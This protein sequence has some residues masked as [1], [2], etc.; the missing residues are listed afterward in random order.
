MAIV[1]DAIAS[2]TSSTPGTLY[3]WSHTVGAALTDDVLV[4]L[5]Y[6]MG[7]Q[8]GDAPFTMTA[9]YDSVP[10]TKAKE[11]QATST[12][13]NYTGTIFVLENPSTGANLVAVTASGAIDALIAT[14][15]SLSGVH[16]TTPIPTTVSDVQVG[17]TLDVAITTV[18][19]N[20]WVLGIVGEDG[21]DDVNYSSLSGVT[22]LHDLHTDS[23]TPSDLEA[24]GATGKLPTTTAGSHTF[25]FS[26]A[27]NN[28]GGMAVAVELQEPSNVIPVI[29]MSYRQRRI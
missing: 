27:S 14:S 21:S 12:N 3:S 29:T 18:S 11:A 17:T 6:G 24:Q 8:S 16:Q 2:E 26:G 7:A 4:V 19:D 1:Q 10:M 23:G 28:V 9:T 20:S 13:R 15:I 22:E 25:G 5:V